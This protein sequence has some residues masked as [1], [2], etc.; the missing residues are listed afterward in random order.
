[1]LRKRKIEL[2]LKKVESDERLH[3]KPANVLVN[4]P[5][6]LIQTEL[7]TTSRVLRIIL[8]LPM[9]AHKLKTGSWEEI[10]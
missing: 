3:Y 5:L 9:C 7:E 8:G 1:M 6:A 4:A 2:W 10:G